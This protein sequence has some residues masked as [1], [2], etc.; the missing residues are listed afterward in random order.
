[1][2]SFGITT[3]RPVSLTKASILL[4]PYT[5]SSTVISTKWPAMPAAATIAGEAKCVLDPAPC[6]PMKFLFD[7]EA[8]C[9]QAG[10]LSG[11]IAKHAEHPGSRHSHPASSNILAIPDLIARFRIARLPGTIQAVTLG[12]K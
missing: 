10:I 5:N 11:F 8:T 12:A 7:V 6:R 2:L 9:F 3:A 1:M 4:F